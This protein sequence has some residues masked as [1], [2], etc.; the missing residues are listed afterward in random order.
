MVSGLAILI[1]GPIIA[2]VVTVPRT[3]AVAQKEGEA[4]AASR[5]QFVETGREVPNIPELRV[6][7]LETPLPTP[8]PTPRPAPSPRSYGTPVAHGPIADIIMAAAARYGVDGNW[9]VRIAS[10]ESGLNPNAYNR[11]GPYIGL[12]QFLPS[13]FQ[14]HGGTNI[15]DPYQQSDIAANMLAHGGARSWPVCSQR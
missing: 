2:A 1:A 5:A 14:A 7:G 15:Y 6:R 3:G 13:T 12:F 4:T 11:S 9:M 10:C 8:T